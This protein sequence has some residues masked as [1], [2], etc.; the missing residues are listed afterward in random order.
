MSLQLNNLKVVIDEFIK[1]IQSD[2]NDKFRNIVIIH[3]LVLVLFTAIYIYNDNK[4]YAGLSKDSTLDK[5]KFGVI[6]HTTIGYGNVYPIE[7]K[8]KIITM[9]HS[10]ITMLVNLFGMYET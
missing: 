3:C 10:L 7:W 8:L 2:D 4:N 1:N 5:I 6:T 9:C